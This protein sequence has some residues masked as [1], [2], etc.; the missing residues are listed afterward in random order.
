[1]IPNVSVTPTLEDIQDV[2]V[3][4]GKHIS[5]LSK[6]VSQWTAGK[7]PRVTLLYFKIHRYTAPQTYQVQRLKVTNHALF[8]SNYCSYIQFDNRVAVR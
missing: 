3:L 5:G 2:L 4:A 6:G 7:T 8:K 1:M